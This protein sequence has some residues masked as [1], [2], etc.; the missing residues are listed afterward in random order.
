ME[1]Y[2]GGSGGIDLELQHTIIDNSDG[3]EPYISETI[4][5]Q[6]LEC[7]NT[8]VIDCVAVMTVRDEVNLCAGYSYNITEDQ[9]PGQ[10]ESVEEVRTGVPLVEETS[11]GNTELD[12]LRSSL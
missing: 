11:C 10:K 2:T 4:F 5:P 3:R 7:Y 8:I 1:R 9:E 6:S 12:E